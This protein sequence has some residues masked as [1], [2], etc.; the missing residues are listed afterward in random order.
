MEM[1]SHETSAKEKLLKYGFVYAAYGRENVYVLNSSEQALWCVHCYIYLNVYV[2][3]S[4][5]VYIFLNNN[6]GVRMRN[7]TAIADEPKNNNTDY[8]FF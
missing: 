7:R 5:A 2:S 3:V 1:E 4:V 6:G 8:V